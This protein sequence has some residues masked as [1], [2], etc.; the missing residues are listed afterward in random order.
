[1]NGVINGKNY[2][3]S[4]LRSK[5]IFRPTYAGCAAHDCQ[6]ESPRL[7]TVGPTY[8]NRR[9]HIR[10]TK[11]TYRLNRIFSLYTKDLIREQEKN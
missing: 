4:A 6:P 10:G 9:A 11:K 5:S 2:N 7:S 1:M 3:A 8:V